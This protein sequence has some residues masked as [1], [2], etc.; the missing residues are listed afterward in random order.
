MPRTAKPEEKRE[1]MALIVRAAARVFRSDGFHKASL[2]DI[3]ASLN[4]TK[5]GLYYYVNA[6]EDLLFACH[7]LAMELV[8]PGL[9]RIAHDIDLAPDEKVR[10]AVANHVAV[11][12]DE[13]NLVTVLLQQEYALPDQSR[14][15]IARLRNR[16]DALMTSILNE[17]KRRG[18]FRRDLDVKIATY[19]LLGSLNWIPHW[20]HKGGRLDI[21][22]IGKEFSSY[23]LA[24][25]M[26]AAPEASARR[27][28]RIKKRVK[29]P[30]GSR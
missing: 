6:K 25:I 27:V 26:S 18:M 22:E 8:L 20:Y 3:A 16:Y 21:S 4:M 24:G 5:G 9:E 1:R 7:R 13:F 12:S 19:A 30:S 15:R 23:F 17:G 14:A 10:Q 29:R 28:P 11:L 2:A